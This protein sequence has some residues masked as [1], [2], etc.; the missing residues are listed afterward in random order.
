LAGVIF[1]VSGT[2]F[3]ET[4]QHTLDLSMLI[5]WA[6][7]Y[8]VDM[9]V[10]NCE[11]YLILAMLDADDRLAAHGIAL[12]YACNAPP[13][14]PER[15]ESGARYLLVDHRRTFNP[16]PSWPPL[17][18]DIQI[19]ADGFAGATI[20]PLIEDPGPLDPQTMGVQSIYYPLNGFFVYLVE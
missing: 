6:E 5:A 12:V 1:I 10:G 9:V 20:T 3:Y 2:R 8:D 16:D 11:N 4:R 14:L 7:A 19:P 18:W 15:I 13:E 17:G